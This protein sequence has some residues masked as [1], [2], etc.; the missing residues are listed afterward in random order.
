MHVHGTIWKERGLLTSGRKENKHLEEILALLDSVMMP[1]EVVVA[2]C[3][4]HQKIDSYLAKGKNLDYQDTKWVA[5]T[6]DLNSM[7]LVCDFS[8]V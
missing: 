4:S 3:L 8:S 2:H 6:K 1:K 5:K 7:G